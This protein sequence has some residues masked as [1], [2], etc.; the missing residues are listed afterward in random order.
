MDM[1]ESNNESKEKELEKLYGTWIK[2]LDN[3]DMG[4]G[5]VYFNV[6]NILPAGVDYVKAIEY[7]MIIILKCLKIS[8]RYGNNQVASLVRL[9]GASPK[10][11]SYR[12]VKYISDMVTDA[13]PGKLKVAHIMQPKSRIY[14]SLVIAFFKM[15]KYCT[16]KEAYEKL[17]LLK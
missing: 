5:V 4:L 1:S 16:H 12:F 8:N 11:F 15:M 2:A 6:E 10:N 17:K 9:E 7:V 3:K 14:K 13:F